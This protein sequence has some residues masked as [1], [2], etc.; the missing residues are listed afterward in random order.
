MELSA[1][2]PAVVLSRL[3]GLHISGAEMWTKEAGSTRANYAAQ[4]S[5]RKGFRRSP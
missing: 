5:R 2:L 1:E 4:L 3:L